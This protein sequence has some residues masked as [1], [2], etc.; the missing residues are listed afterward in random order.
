MLSNL[1]LN[2]LGYTC[3]LDWT[4]NNKELSY[5]IP[6]TRSAHSN[7]ILEEVASSAHKTILFMQLYIWQNKDLTLQLI[8]RAEKNG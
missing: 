2:I 4:P 3:D 5:S 1:G 7:N 6:I 8:Q